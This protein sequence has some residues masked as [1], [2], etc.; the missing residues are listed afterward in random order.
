MKTDKFQDLVLNH[1]AK[2]TQE[3]TELKSGQ[4]EIVDRLDKLDVDLAPNYPVRWI[5]ALVTL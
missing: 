5:R 3:M 4:K 1:L 2:L